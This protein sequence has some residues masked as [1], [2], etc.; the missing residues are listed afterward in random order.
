MATVLA[1]LDTTTQ[2]I[3]MHASE[4]PPSRHDDVGATKWD[5]TEA[6]SGKVQCR[7]CELPVTV[8]VGP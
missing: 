2:R 3:S 6:F 4:L 5:I 1:N 7:G 8:S